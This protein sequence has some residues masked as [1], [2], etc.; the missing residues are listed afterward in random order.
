MPVGCDT[1]HGEHQGWNSHGRKPRHWPPAGFGHRSSKYASYANIRSQGPLGVPHGV[2]SCIM[3]PAV[4]KYNIKHGS[5]N[6]QIQARQ[7]QVRDILWSDSEVAATLRA[8]GLSDTSD[9]G[10]LLDA[11]IRALGLPRSLHELQIG[12]DIIPA[13]SKRALDDFWAPS[14]PIPLLE[15]AQVQEILEAVA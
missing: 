12:R 4:M 15:A 11:I 1:C 13:L 8:A 2:T 14:N 3:C 10:D 9:L 6:P 7:N 5:E